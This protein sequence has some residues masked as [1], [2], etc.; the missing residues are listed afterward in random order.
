MKNKEY[1]DRFV[2][3]SAEIVS[4]PAKLIAEA[5]NKLFF[6]PEFIVGRR[7]IYNVGRNKAKR[8]RRE[9]QRQQRAKTN[10]RSMRVTD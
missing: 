1:T 6:G 8:E 10:E 4:N 5:Q 3:I 9:L 7:W 2:H